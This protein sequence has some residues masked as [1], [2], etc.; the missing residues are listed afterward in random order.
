MSCNIKQ[1]VALNTPSRTKSRN[2]CIANLIHSL[3]AQIMANIL[4]KFDEMGLYI[5][6]IHDCFLISIKHYDLLLELYHKEL[7]NIYIN[8]K[9]ILLSYNY[10]DEKFINT[11]PKEDYKN[12]IIKSRTGLKC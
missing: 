1:F 10:I 12:E 8:R 5:D 9:N 2:A 7:Y 11:L 4:I 3:D 6:T